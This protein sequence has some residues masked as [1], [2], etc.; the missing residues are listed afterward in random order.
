MTP[1]FKSRI[2]S[3][4][5][6]ALV[7]LLFVG[8]MGCKAKPSEKDC[9][10]AINNVRRI[11]GQEGSD[12]GADPIAMIRSC[13]GSSNQKSVDCMLKAKTG[14]DLV[15]CEGEAGG[16]YFKSEV[17]ATEKRIKE[18]G[19]SGESGDTPDE[20]APSEGTPTEGAPVVTPPAETPPA[21]TPAAETPPSEGSGAAPTKA[22]PAK[23]AT[24]KKAT[25]KKATPAKAA[26]RDGGH[27]TP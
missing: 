1:V 15:G 17:E 10:D 2:F 13:R 20:G 7:S 22:V 6:L 5:R 25:P 26:H 12:M 3:V 16:K 19:G 18:S 4:L 27:A 21:K 9:K 14:A 23:E 24:P 11:N 8:T